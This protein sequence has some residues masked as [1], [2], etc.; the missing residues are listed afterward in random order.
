MSDLALQGSISDIKL[1]HRIDPDDFPITVILRA[2]FTVI[3]AEDFVSTDIDLVNTQGWQSTAKLGESIRPDAA[4]P[5]VHE[6]IFFSLTKGDYTATW[7]VR[8]HDGT[9]IAIGSES[10]ILEG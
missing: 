6:G 2:E 3:D 8:R 1:T 7:Y 5:Q 4:V 9:R 10:F